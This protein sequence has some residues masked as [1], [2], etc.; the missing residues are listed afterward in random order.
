MVI[1]TAIV[2]FPAAVVFPALAFAAVVIPTAMTFAT[3]RVSES[4]RHSAEGD[5]AGHQ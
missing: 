3:R 2:S 4:R 5:H 1:P